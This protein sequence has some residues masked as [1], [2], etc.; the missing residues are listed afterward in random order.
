LYLPINLQIQGFISQS[1]GSIEYGETIKSKEYQHKRL[2]LI[3]QRKIH[4]I[5]KMEETMFIQYWSKKLKNDSKHRKSVLIQYTMPNN[6]LKQDKIF[7]IPNKKIQAAALNWR[8]S[9]TISPESEKPQK[10][11]KIMCKTCN[12]ECKRNH[13]NLCPGIKHNTNLIPK[14]LWISFEKTKIKL[15]QTNSD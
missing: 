3:Q 6:K 15:C 1:H 9:S 12:K 4:D 11:A 10:N 14:R 5:K 13:S 7:Q 8:L 2:N